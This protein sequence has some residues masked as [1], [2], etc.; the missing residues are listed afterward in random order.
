MPLLPSSKEFYVNLNPGTSDKHVLPF[1]LVYFLQETASR[2]KGVDISTGESIIAIY[3]NHCFHVRD[4][5][6]SVRETCC[7]GY[8]QLRVR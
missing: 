2:S 6:F 7:V 8:H 4:P 3:S 5:L 1:Y